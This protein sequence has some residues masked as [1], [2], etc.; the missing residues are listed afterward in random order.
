MAVLRNLRLM[1]ASGVDPQLVAAS[2]ARKRKERQYFLP[3]F[4]SLDHPLPA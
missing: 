2:S 4:F 3:C 1:L